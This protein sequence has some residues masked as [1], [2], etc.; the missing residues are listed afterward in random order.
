ELEQAVEGEP[1][2][3]TR[4]ERK[5]SGRE[6]KRGEGGTGKSDY[7]TLVQEDI[8]TVKERVEREGLDPSEVL[9]AEK[10]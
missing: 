9:R 7:E 10:K 6:E 4:E 1:E 2:T 3:R 5:E 8:D